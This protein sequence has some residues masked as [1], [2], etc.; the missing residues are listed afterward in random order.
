MFK[1]E[2]YQIF[3]N[4]ISATDP[5]S[6]GTSPQLFFFFF[7]FF[8]F[9]PLATPYEPCVRGSFFRLLERCLEI[10]MANGFGVLISFHGS[11][12]L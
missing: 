5:N 12:K 1:G 7:F 6:D 9:P 8:F 10:I 3:I 2:R 11:P 4:I